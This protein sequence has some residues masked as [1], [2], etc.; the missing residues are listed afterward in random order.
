MCSECYSWIIVLHL[1]LKKRCVR[2]ITSTTLFVHQF[3][4]WC[5]DYLNVAQREIRRRHREVCVA[6]LARVSHRRQLFRRKSSMSTESA[7]HERKSKTEH[8]ILLNLFFIVVCSLYES[9]S[10]LQVHLNILGSLVD[11]T[12]SS[13][14]QR[15][16]VLTRL[17]AVASVNTSSGNILWRQVSDVF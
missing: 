13:N 15:A 2:Q 14:G 9:E 16:F 17:G 6:I 5:S 4:L 3:V 12:F 8:M 7:R 1:N 10:H 11:A